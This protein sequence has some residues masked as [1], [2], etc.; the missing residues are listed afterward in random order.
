MKVVILIQ[1][2]VKYIAITVKKSKIHI[3]EDF[4]YATIKKLYQDSF[5]SIL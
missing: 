1:M 2:I 4:I 5:S 3:I